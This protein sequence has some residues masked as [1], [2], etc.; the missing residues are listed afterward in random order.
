MLQA[1]NGVLTG[2]KAPTHQQDLANSANEFEYSEINFNKLVYEVRRLRD[3]RLKDQEQIIKKNE[4]LIVHKEQL[5]ELLQRY[6]VNK[7]L[8][9]VYRGAV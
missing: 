8:M 3:A 4:E 1:A 7:P 9:I 5:I 6:E 2:G